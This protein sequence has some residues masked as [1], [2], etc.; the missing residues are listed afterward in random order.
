[1]PGE[2]RVQGSLQIF[3]ENTTKKCPQILYAGAAYSIAAGMLPEV[4][5]KA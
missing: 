4:S 1:M 5:Y 2:S 3:Y